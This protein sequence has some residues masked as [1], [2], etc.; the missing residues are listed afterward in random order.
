[1]RAEKIEH[2]VRELLQ[3]VVIDL[4]A[5]ENAQEIFETLNARGAHLTAADLI[6]NFVFQRLMEA[7]R[8]RRGRLR[9]ALE[10]VRDRL[11]GGR[12]QL[13]AAPLLAIVD[14]PEPLADRP[15]RRGDRRPGGVRP[16]QALRR[17]RGRRPDG[18]ARRADPPGQRGLPV[19]H[20]GSDRQQPD[21]P[22]AAV[23]LPDERARE[24]GLQAGR[25]VAAR[26]RAGARSRDD[27]FTRRSTCS[28]AGSSVACSSERQTSSY[29]QVAAE[30]VT[31][32]R[33]SDRHCAGDVVEG[34][35]RRPDRRQPLLARRQRGRPGTGLDLLAYRRLRRGRLRMVLEAIEDHRRGWH[36]DAE[37]LGG[38]RVARGKFH[39]E[40]V[41]P[42]RWQAQLA[43]RATA[44]PR[45]IAID[46]STPSATSR[47]SPASSTARSRTRAWTVKRAALKNT[48]C[49]KLNSNLTPRPDDELERRQDRARTR[50]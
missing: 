46:S 26:P 47:C 23:R 35:L 41:M 49:S 3:L 37:G 42:R 22:P 18:R 29:T 13:R 7:G 40:H 44:P 27:Q 11:L 45:P 10:G 21:R 20:R 8:R 16:V 31:Q 5:D 25:P 30:L 34:V 17:L 2:A 39:I 33:K 38:E 43:A 19:V 24:R 50:R 6:K 9:A 12:G 15:H 14:L 36:G 28:R 48:T 1:M 4:T 32:L